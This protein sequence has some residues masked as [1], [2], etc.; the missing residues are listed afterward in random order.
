MT[1]ACNPSSCVAGVFARVYAQLWGLGASIFG[2]D[3]LPASLSLLSSVV[4][5]A[6]CVHCAAHDLKP[7]DVVEVDV[8]SATAASVKG[9]VVGRTTLSA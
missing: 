2:H 3:V 5:Y 8:T 7:G 9:T 1:P 6:L 4:L